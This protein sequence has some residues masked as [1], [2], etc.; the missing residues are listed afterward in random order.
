MSHV[1][2]HYGHDTDVGESLSVHG[3][4][5]V[6]ARPGDHSTCGPRGVFLNLMKLKQTHDEAREVFEPHDVM[7]LKKPHDV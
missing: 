5:L 1:S 6:L 2:Y 7:R 3:P 4:I